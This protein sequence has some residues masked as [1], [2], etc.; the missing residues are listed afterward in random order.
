MSLFFAVCGTEAVLLG[1]CNVCSFVPTIVRVFMM[2]NVE[3][4]HKDVVSDIPGNPHAFS[5]AIIS[6]FRTLPEPSNFN[7]VWTGLSYNE[8]LLIRGQIP[9]CRFSSVSVYDGSGSGDAPNSVELLP[10]Q[11]MN[12]RACEVVIVPEGVE[13][14]DVSPGTLILRCNN[15]KKGFVSMRNYLVPPGTR[16]ITPEIVRL[17]D[18]VVVRPANV[19]VAGPCGLDL[20]TSK[21]AKALL[22]CCGIN[23]T[24][25][26]INKHLLRGLLSYW[27]TVLV[28]AVGAC[29]GYTMYRMCFILGKKRLNKLTADLCPSE[30]S[31]FF[32]SLEAGSKAS[33]PS[34]LHKYW[35]MKHDIPEGSEV[36]VRAKINPAF[37]KYWSLVVYDEFG[38]PLPQYVYDENALKIPVSGGSGTTKGK[39]S[40]GADSS[41][42]VYEVDIRLRNG[43]PG[44][45]APA[46]VDANVVDMSDCAV[47]YVLFR[48]NHPVGEHVVE[49][50]TPDAKLYSEHRGQGQSSAG[51]DNK[52]KSK[53]A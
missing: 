15:W 10:D 38:L 17:R 8:P 48:V 1:V 45:S 14:L 16:V 21:W 50:S 42:G 26:L 18:G 40:T 30:N 4:F 53:R 52:K 35:M 9:L 32:A 44:L 41:N 6:L 49:F 51:V 5:P 33:Q 36:V 34:K 29:V 20:R 28:M 23:A 27:H 2:K 47:G 25:L 43:A 13:N 31:F 39:K 24:L 7:L 46:E 37:Q 19:Q 12:T 3:S 11:D 22:R